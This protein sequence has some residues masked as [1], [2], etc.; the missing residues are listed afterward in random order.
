MNEHR[1]EFIDFTLA[2]EVLRFGDFTL[3]S[4][5][6][7]PYFFNAGRF[8]TGARLDRLGGF[9]ARTVVDAGV[10]FDMVFGPAYKGVPLACALAIA[11]AGSHG[12]DV[13]YSFN[14]KE[15]KDHGEGGIIAGAPLAG[16]VLVVD[17]V[18]SAGTSVAESMRLI[19][20]AGAHPAGVLIA[21]DR[22]ERGSGARS[23]VQE[24]AQR[25]GV[26][27]LS[28]IALADLIEYLRDAP[29][30]EADLERIERYRAE[31]G[32]QG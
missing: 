5:R 30:R 18:I 32:V 19:D 21:L 10:D 31:Y 16:R 7:S 4:G 6:R 17:D 9:Y 26:P 24:V 1:R 29:G 22:Q 13:P 25:H 28:I 12:L 27:V 3:K 15:I 20:A 23:A 14:R 2:C 11:L 8:D